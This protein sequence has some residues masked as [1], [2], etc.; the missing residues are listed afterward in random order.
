MAVP[1]TAGTCDVKG[2]AY[3][4]TDMVELREALVQQQRTLEQ[5]A[6]MA[7]IGSWEVDL[8]TSTP[9]DP[10]SR[11]AGVPLSADPLPRTSEPAK[12]SR[13]HVSFHLRQGGSSPRCVSENGRAPTPA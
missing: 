11:C 7:R 4:A 12:S 3:D 9:A 2:I 5:A 8:R 1:V 10:R 13:K 6:H